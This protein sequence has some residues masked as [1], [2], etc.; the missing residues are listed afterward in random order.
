MWH[1]R[2]VHQE[3]KDATIDH[4]YKWKGNRHLCDNHRGILLLKIAGKIFACILPNGLY[5]HLEQGCLP[6]T[7]GGFRRYCGTTKGIVAARQVKN[8]C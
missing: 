2:Q 6:E 8:K 5:G 4:L 1:Q 7:H 3:L